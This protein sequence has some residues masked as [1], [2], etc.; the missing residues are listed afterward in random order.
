[1]ANHSFQ[2]CDLR[3]YLEGKTV[4]QEGGSYSVTWQKPESSPLHSYLDHLATVEK[5]RCGPK[6]QLLGTC[7]PYT[8]PAAV[9]QPLKTV[10]S[11][12]ELIFDYIYVYLDQDG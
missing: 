7:D 8:A 1:M 9:F 3:P 6:L 5:E 2:S 4:D 12:S 10:R 11:L